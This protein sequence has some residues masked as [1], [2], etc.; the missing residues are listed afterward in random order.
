MRGHIRKHGAGYQYTVDLD[1][2]P[3]TGYR[4]QKSKGGFKTLRLAEKEMNQL[5]AQIERGDYFEV[6]EM[7]IND[8]LEYWLKT[9]AKLKT[10]ASTYKRYKEFTNT[11]IKYIG[12]IK[13]SQLKPMHLQKFYSDLINEGKLSN[14]TILKIHRMLHLAFK[15]AVGWEMLKSNPA[16]AVQA[17]RAEIIEMHVWDADTVNEF[18]ETIKDKKLYIPVLLA[19]QTGMREGEICALRWKDVD[20]KNGSIHVTKNMQCLNGEIILKD[21]KTKKSKRNIALM[22][23]TIDILKNHK[24][25]QVLSINEDDNFVCCHED[26]RP[27]RT[28]Y[29]SRE[30][31]KLLKR[32]NIEY[33]EQKKKAGYKVKDTDVKFPVIRFHDLRHTHATL[34]LQA[35]INPKIVSERLGH[36]NISITLDTYSHV[37]PDMQREA[38]EKL[39]DLFQNKA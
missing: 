31:A 14:S 25:K 9:Y 32:L 8:Y 39:D 33:Q 1:P 27:F 22:K 16:D 20:F 13:M 24:S 29:V 26:G 19:L 35:G 5:I 28:V 2:D 15:N 18:L 7:S 34:M 36:A 4:R 30:F 12:K 21:P 6:C 37:L 23:S 10:A 11:A 38:V 3:V 17:P